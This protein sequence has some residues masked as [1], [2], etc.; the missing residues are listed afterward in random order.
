M[1]LSGVIGISVGVL[2]LI[3]TSA[4]LPDTTPAQDQTQRGRV[5]EGVYLELTR[6]F[7]EALRHE[8]DR[9]AMVYT[10]D[11]SAVHLKEIA[12]STRFMVQTNLEILKQQE[13]MIQLLRRL[14]ETR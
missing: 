7:Y 5:P 2:G 6:D 1:K 10:N 13:T 14:T 8:G 11:P 3:T 4:I 12:V 9:S